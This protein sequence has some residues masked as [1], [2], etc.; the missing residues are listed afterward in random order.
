MPGMSRVFRLPYESAPTPEFGGWSK[1]DI[2]AHVAF[3]IAFCWNGNRD[4]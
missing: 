2:Q 1:K 4:G 3:M